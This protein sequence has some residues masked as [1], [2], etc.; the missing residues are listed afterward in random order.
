MKKAEAE[1]SENKEENKQTNLVW[2]VAAC[3]GKAEG[4]FGAQDT[5]TTYYGEIVKLY[6]IPKKIKEN[7]FFKISVRDG[8]LAISPDKTKYIV[9]QDNFVK[10]CKTLKEINICKINTIYKYFGNNCILDIILRGKKSFRNCTLQYFEVH[11][12]KFIEMERINQLMV[13]TNNKIA[14]KLGKVV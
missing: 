13:I 11:E 12:P 9:L 10:K 3:S 4:R 7:K 2:I 5:R 1:K 6:A 14:V 8:T